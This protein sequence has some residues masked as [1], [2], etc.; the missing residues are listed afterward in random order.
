MDRIRLY[1]RFSNMLL[2]A[3]MEYRLNFFMSI[4]LSFV[5]FSIDVLGVWTLMNS[6]HTV[7][8][9]VLEEVLLLVGLNRIAYGISASFLWDPLRRIGRLIQSGEFDGLMTR[10]IG[11]FFHLISRTYGFFFLLSSLMG[12]GMSIYCLVHLGIPMD[13]ARIVLLILFVAG[14]VLIQSAVFIIS[15]SLSFWFINTTTLLD[16]LVGDV[17]NF[18]AY[19][20][21][22]YPRFIQ[23]LLTFLLPYAFVNYYPALFFLG[24]TGEAPFTPMLVFATPLAG[25]AMAAVAVLFWK[26]GLRRYQSTG[27]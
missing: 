19:P 2:K 27:S 16:V 17:R 20:V 12:V 8:G 26:S 11:T 21:G 18:I 15:G 3:M 14:A 5:W 22:I 13:L 10:P 24:R 25:I 1:I 7:N 9:W 6:F 4:L 23:F